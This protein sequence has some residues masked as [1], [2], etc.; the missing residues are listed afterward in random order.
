MKRV[1]NTSK[2][3]PFFPNQKAKNVNDQSYSPSENEAGAV[4]KDKSQSDSKVS[5]PLG[6]KVFSRIKKLVDKT[7]PKNNMEKIE[8][9]RNEIQAGNYYVNENILADKVLQNEFGLWRD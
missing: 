5:I 7:P 1:E 4:P 8:Q 9:L 6:T 2:R 3:T